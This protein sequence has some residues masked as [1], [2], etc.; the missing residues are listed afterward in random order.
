MKNDIR[1]YGVGAL[2]YCP[3][4]KKSIVDS[5]TTEAFGTKFSLAL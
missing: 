1:Y 4:N 3:A 5:I 2:L